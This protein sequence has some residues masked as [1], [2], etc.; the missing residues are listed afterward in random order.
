M[1]RGGFGVMVD[2]LAA[3]FFALICLALMQALLPT[4]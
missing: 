4:L 2:D 3:A 1:F